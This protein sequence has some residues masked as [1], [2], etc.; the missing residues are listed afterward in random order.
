MIGSDCWSHVPTHHNSADIASRGVYPSALESLDAWWNGPNFLRLQW[1]FHVPDQVQH[2]ETEEECRQIRAHTVQVT[3]ELIS[4]I[5]HKFSSLLKVTRIIA[6][7]L[8]FKNNLRSMIWARQNSQNNNHSTN[9]T[10]KTAATK[11]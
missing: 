7:W 6:W 1:D 5:T 10:N 9:F 8:R 2:V 11:R 3:R 4:I